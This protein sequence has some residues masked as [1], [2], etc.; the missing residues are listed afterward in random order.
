MP[1]SEVSYVRS[2]IDRAARI[3]GAAARRRVALI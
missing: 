3:G 1:T 2:E